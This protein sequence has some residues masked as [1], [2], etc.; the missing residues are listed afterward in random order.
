MLVGNGRWSW[1][2]LFEDVRKFAQSLRALGTNCHQAENAWGAFGYLN[3]SHEIFS[4]LVPSTR[5]LIFAKAVSRDVDVSSANGEKPQSSVVPSDSGG[6]NSAASSTRSRT[7]S[8]L[9]ILGLI[10]SV[11][12]TNRI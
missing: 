3:T 4:S 2:R 7:T 9:S 12:P 10:G 6:T 8:G 5:L 11:T 1:P